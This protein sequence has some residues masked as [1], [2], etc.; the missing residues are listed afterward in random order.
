MH[1]R[2]VAK[3]KP[4]PCFKKVMLFSFLNNS[5]K[6]KPSLIIFGT[7]NHEKTSHEKIINL[8]PHL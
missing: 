4:T 8:P 3:G 6:N 7:H 1:V 2:A 5:V